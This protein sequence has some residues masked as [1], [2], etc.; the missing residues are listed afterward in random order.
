MKV[1]NLGELQW[2]QTQL[3]YHTL[4]NM[5]IECLLLHST[6][7]KYVC[8]GLH[9]DPRTEIDINYCKKN[10]IGIFRRETGGGIVL[11]D[12]N[13][14]FFNIILKK[15]NPI[16][17]RFP[18]N[19]FKKFLQPVIKTCNEF[20]IKTEFHPICDLVVNGK[21]ISGNGGGELGECNV[22]VGN[23]LLDFN[24]RQMTK[25]INSP[26]KLKESYYN[27]MKQNITT[28]K[29]ELGYIPSKEKMYKV[30]TT[31]YLELLG[32]LEI[33]EVNEEINNQIDKLDKKYFSDEWMYQRGVKKNGYEIKIREGVFLFYKIIKTLNG[34]V[35]IICQTE[36]NII[37]ETIFS[38]SILSLKDNV[39]K[40]RKK[41]IG[42]EYKKVDL[43]LLIYDLIKKYGGVTVA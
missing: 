30:L 13:Q 32:P 24:Y 17:P 5:N 1:F 10:N 15:S 42:M 25:V 22:L 33:G 8:V 12:K 38:G 40:I 41:L 28:V 9:Q 4:A 39:G 43:D 27:L 2:K 6:K 31:K 29:E 19:F 11:L 14:L 16:V 34:N 18:Q 7:Q 35:E 3:I 20:E 23:I 26:K 36:E 37:K 21:K